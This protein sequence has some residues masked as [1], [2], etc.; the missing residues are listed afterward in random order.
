LPSQIDLSDLVADLSLS[1]LRR[2]PF[3]SPRSSTC[4]SPSCYS[5]DSWID[6]DDDDESSSVSAAVSASPVPTLPTLPSLTNSALSPSSSE[7]SLATVA[8]P[9]PFSPVFEFDSDDVHCHWSES[10]GQG[11]ERYWPECRV[12]SSDRAVAREKALGRLN[13]G[14]EKRL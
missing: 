8:I 13:E 2:S 7:E 1:R 11:E 3:P 14:G 10:V 5:T 12:C 4:S 6:G 9:E